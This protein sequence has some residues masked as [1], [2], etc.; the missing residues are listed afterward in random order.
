VVITQ[1]GA[2]SKFEQPPQGTAQ[3]GY[4]T[5]VWTAHDEN[6]DELRYAV[7]FRGENE[8]EWKLLKDNLEQK[9]YS[10][11]TTTMPDGAYYLKIGASDAPSN[12]PEDAL[13]AERESDRFEVDNSP[14]VVENL[15]AEA[16]S[17][18]VRARFDARDSSS[19]I[20]RAEYSLDAGDWT[21]LF[22]VGRLA[23]SPQLSYE[24]YLRGLA[25][26]E[27]TLPVRVLDRLDTGATAKVTFGVPP[28]KR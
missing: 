19:N 21:V 18:D 28:K 27:P 1:S 24:V 6:E 7:Y 22:P 5:V 17:P 4:Q 11:D 13:T 8:R 25:V 2:P 16:A 10:W 15:R 3:K 26:G 20:V 12:P 9:F 14:P 23:D